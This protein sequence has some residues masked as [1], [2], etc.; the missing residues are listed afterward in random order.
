MNIHEN[1]EDAY[2]K[3]STKPELENIQMTP[4]F[5]GTEAELK[6]F[7][8]NEYAKQALV[9]VFFERLSE[10]VDPEDID[11]MQGE[12][13]NY[14]EE[15]ILSVL[16]LPKELAEKNFTQFEQRLQ[17]GDSPEE[18]MRDYI[19]KVAKYQFSI[20]FHTSPRDIKPSLEDGSWGIKGSEKDHRDNDRLMAY[21]SVQYRHLFKK[22]GSKYIY[23]VRASPQDKSDEDKNWFRNDTLSII[24]RLKLHEVINYVET[25][26]RQE[27][28]P[29]DESKA[30][31]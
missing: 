18:V 10:Y 29:A 31:G 24:T 3:L 14:S 9:G 7:L 12:M 30:G 16:A 23:I 21:Y 4:D 5:E 17:A 26:A 27:K 11:R 6:D 19:Q 25:N 8:F 15:E 2:D 1:P 28:S 20:G 13:V 22:M